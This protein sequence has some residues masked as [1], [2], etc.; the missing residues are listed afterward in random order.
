MRPASDSLRSPDCC[1]D[2]MGTRHWPDQASGY[3]VVFVD[4]MPQLLQIVMRMFEQLGCAGRCFQDPGEALEHIES[5]GE[6]VAL[7][8]TDQSMGAMSGL[9]LIDALQGLPVT[10]PSVLATSV[11]S[12]AVLAEYRSR[13]VCALL[14]KPFSLTELGEV[15]G[16]H[17][18]C[19]S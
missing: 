15:I 2:I 10:P 12:E 16:A 13:G 9:E 18:V 11:Q 7:V 8:I 5:R 14:R 4:D 6:H 19:G 1:G 17:A 3:E